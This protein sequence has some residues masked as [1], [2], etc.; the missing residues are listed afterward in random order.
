MKSQIRMTAVADWGLRRLRA[1][2]GDLPLGFDLLLYLEVDIEE[3]R[4]PAVPPSH[5]GVLG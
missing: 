4:D 3:A 1:L 5:L 2:N